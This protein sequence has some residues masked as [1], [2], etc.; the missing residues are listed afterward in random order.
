MQLIKIK[1]KPERVGLK[2]RQ[3]ACDGE[4]PGF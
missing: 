3:K 1:P 2:E 4:R